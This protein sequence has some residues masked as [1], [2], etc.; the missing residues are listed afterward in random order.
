[1]KHIRDFLTSEAGF[2]VLFALGCV[3]GG[4]LG[5]V[6]ALWRSSCAF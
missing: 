5:V 3:G 1:M 6:L 4:Y 2:L